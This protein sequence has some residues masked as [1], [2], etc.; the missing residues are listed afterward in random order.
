MP[1]PGWAAMGTSIDA[2]IALLGN[3]FTGAVAK[4]DLSKGE[5]VAQAETNVER[6]LAGIA[7]YPG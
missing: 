3:F 1:G 7:Q 5:I 2:N 4:F 6:S